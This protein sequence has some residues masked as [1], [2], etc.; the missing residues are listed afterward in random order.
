MQEELKEYESK[1][2]Q[3]KGAIAANNYKLDET[4]VKQVAKSG[5][6]ME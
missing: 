5:E 3:L 4:Y 2:K 1:K 6:E